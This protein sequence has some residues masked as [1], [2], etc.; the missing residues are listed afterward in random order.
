MFYRRINL[1]DRVSIISQ[2]IIIFHQF[3]LCIIITILVRVC[4]LSFICIKKKN[5]PVKVLYNASVVEFTWTVLPIFFLLALGGPCFYILY[6]IE[7]EATK[8][9]IDVKITR[10]Q[11]YWS[12]EGN[13]YLGAPYS[14]DSYMKDLN[15]LTIRESRLLEV[16]NHLLLPHKHNVRLLITSSDVLHSWA[17]PKIAIK[18]DAIPRRLNIIS[19]RSLTPRSFYRQCS[20]ICGVNH[21][22]IPIHV[23][24][25]HFL[26]ELKTTH[27]N[28]ILIRIG[29]L[30]NEKI[31]AVILE[32]RR[33][34]RRAWARQQIKNRIDKPVHVSFEEDFY[35]YNY[36]I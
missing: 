25:T 19:I 33:K 9:T 4:L 13:N 5:L 34:A 23:E 3:C 24:F 12:Y 31:R 36:S 2:N 26:T 10:H 11:W 1:I 18:V 21:S 7:R 6:T 20:E 14:F 22:F 29:Q 30:I 28:D 8:Y 16:D 17:L 15:E 32:R 35:K 27:K